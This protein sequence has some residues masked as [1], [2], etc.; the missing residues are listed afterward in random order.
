MTDESWDAVLPPLVA[1]AGID[2]TLGYSV[3]PLSGGVSSDIVVIRF[4]DGRRICAKR[5]LTKLKVASDWRVPAERNHYEVAWLRRAGEIVPGSAPAVLAEDR[6]HGIALL[7]Y[8]PPEDYLLW[9]QELLSG[10]CD[11]LVSAAVAETIGRI[12]AATL[13][14]AATA[15]AFATDRLFDALRL[16]PYLR[17]IAGRYPE[18]ADAI[19]ERISVT[20]STKIALVHGD[21][22]PKNILVHRIDGRPVILDAECAWF[23]DPVFDAAFCLNHLVLKAIHMPDIAEPLLLQA[24]AFL[25]VWLDHFPADMLPATA[26]RTAALLPC[27]MLARIDGKSPVEYLSKDARQRVRDIAIPLIAEAPAS[28]GQVLAAVGTGPLKLR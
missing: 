23:G 5:A 7:E 18:L 4:D 24:A 28:V 10:R 15:R 26:E 1:A 12:H 22:S 27:L 9:K 3:Q 8:L 21:L 6:D 13:G 2:A 19:A 25:Q 14:D 20:A 17:T 11:P 16:D